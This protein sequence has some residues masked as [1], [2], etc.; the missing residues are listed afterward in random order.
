LRLLNNWEDVIKTNP[1][2]IT[3]TLEDDGEISVTGTFLDQQP[4]T[5]LSKGDES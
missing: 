4:S 2:L 3:V 5:T 1:D